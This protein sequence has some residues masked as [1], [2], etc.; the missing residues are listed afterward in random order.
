[1]PIIFISYRR[2]DT[3]GYAGRLCD[4]IRKEFGRE[5]VFIDVDT[6]RPGDDFVDAIN[7]SL[8]K[9]DLMLAVIGKRW[10]TDVDEQGRP[11]LEDE[12]DYVRIEIET[13]LNRRLRTIPVLVDRASMP[14]LQDLP[15]S[16]R[17]LARRQATELSDTRW[18]YDVS[19]LV[20]HLKHISAAAV[21]VAIPPVVL[22]FA[23]A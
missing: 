6:L 12:G 8:E 9:C 21:H 3:S 20:Q 5:N 14:R 10:L 4:R 1:M 23:A 22:M 16:L 19:T 11:R 18:E 2:D 13:A 17:P 7:N 15:E